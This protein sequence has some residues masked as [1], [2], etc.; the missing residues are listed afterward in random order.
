VAADLV[1][2]ELASLDVVLE[3]SKK[4]TSWRKA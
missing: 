3:E 2:D 1:R 4:G